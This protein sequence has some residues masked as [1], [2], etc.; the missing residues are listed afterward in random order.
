LFEVRNFRAG[1]RRLV[2]S[3]K[4]G[5]YFKH[6]VEVDLPS[7]PVV[8]IRLPPPHLLEVRVVDHAGDPV[9]NAA[10]ELSIQL[11]SPGPLD[12]DSIGVERTDEEGVAKVW[13]L[14]NQ[15]MELHVWHWE[16]SHDSGDW[17]PDRAVYRDTRLNDVTLSSG[18][19]LRVVLRD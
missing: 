12:G 8:T 10:V 2:V 18:R 5:L 19:P 7:A 9:S 15:P 13:G 11:G 17:H 6:V 14:R 16:P 1:R 3:S 4:V